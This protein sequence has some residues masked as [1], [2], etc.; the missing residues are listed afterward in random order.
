MNIQRLA[1]IFILT[2]ILCSDIIVV[3][4]LE[5]KNSYGHKHDFKSM[6]HTRE[7]KIMIN[8]S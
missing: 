5:L 7:T 3:T 1:L 8:N 6:L 4:L 2:N